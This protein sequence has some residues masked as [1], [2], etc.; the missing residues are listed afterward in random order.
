MAGRSTHPSPVGGSAPL[1]QAA[2][3]LQITQA[4]PKAIINCTG[5]SIG[6][7]ERVRFIQPG[8]TATALNR[9]VGGETSQIL[10]QLLANGRIFLINPNGIIFGAGAQV[11]VGSLLATTLSISDADFMA[12]NYVFR[13][14]NG[15]LSSIVNLGTLRA[16]DGGFIALSAPGVVNQGTITARLGT[17]HLSSAERLTV[18]F[19][20]DGL[21]RFDVSG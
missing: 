5:F 11:N 4:T 12:G 18:D 21:V 16:A 14:E 15:N 9:V 20:G 10:G 13:R 7:N 1:T 6:S 8:S 2:R 3:S 17:V 19:S